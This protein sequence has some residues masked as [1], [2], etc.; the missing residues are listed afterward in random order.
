MELK[1]VTIEKPQDTNFIFGQSHFI[2]TVE[3]IYETIVTTNP[4]M[5]F[6]LAF[7]EA[8]AGALVR[9]SGNDEHLIKLAEKNALNIGAG[10][11]FIIFME[12]GFPLNILNAVKM[13]PEVV[14]IF[15]ATA[16]PTEVILAETEMGNAV[17]GVVDGQRPK[18]VESE[19][20][21][22]KRKDFLRMIGYKF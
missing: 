12:N 8:S 18:G 22:K 11:S 6:G 7:C 5:K 9:L 15:C 14:R 3:D 17:L 16:N 21:V 13:V 4:G 1:S 10:H 19:N 2:K 20:D